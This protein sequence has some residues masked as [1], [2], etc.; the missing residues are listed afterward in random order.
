MTFHKKKNE[1]LP[2][3]LENYEINNFKMGIN[4]KINTSIDIEC[5]IDKHE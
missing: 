4:N 5:I 3:F 1:N 2:N